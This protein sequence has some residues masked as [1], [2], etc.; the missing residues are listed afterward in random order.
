MVSDYNTRHKAKRI[1]VLS[2]PG[3]GLRRRGRPPKPKPAVSEAPKK[4]RGR[5]PKTLLEPKPHSHS[6]QKEVFDGVELP[7]RSFFKAKRKAPEEIEVQVP[8]QGEYAHSDGL[9]EQ[10][11]DASSLASSNKGVFKR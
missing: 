6:S 3:P 2:D 9:P 1:R 11:G 4:R 5:P 7:V 10:N 8:E